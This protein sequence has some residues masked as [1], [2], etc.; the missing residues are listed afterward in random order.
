VFVE[1]QWTPVVLILG[2][3]NLKLSWG[4]NPAWTS[5]PGL[6]P[7][8]YEVL[9]NSTPA[10][11]VA[12]DYPND[13]TWD[14]TDSLGEGGIIKYDFAGIFAGSAKSAYLTKHFQCTLGAVVPVT[15][16]FTPAP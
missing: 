16:T 1:V 7:T 10:A 15:A 8:W 3:E 12:A 11:T 5:H 2:C 9:R 13:V 14:S 4:P 6:G